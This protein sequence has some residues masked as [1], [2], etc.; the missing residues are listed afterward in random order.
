MLSNNIL[1]KASLLCI[2]VFSVGNTVYASA[3]GLSES[4]SSFRSS[5]SLKPKKSLTFNTRKEVFHYPNEEAVEDTD[6][7]FGA[8]VIPVIA[9]V[10]MEKSK[11]SD[12]RSIVR[13]N[14]QAQY[15]EYLAA[16]T[17]FLSRHPDIVDEELPGILGSVSL[18]LRL[19]KE[20]Y[21]ENETRI[22]EIDQLIDSLN[23]PDVSLDDIYDMK[24]NYMFKYIFYYYKKLIKLFN[25]YNISYNI[26]Y[27]IWQI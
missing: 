27:L 6:D 16:W 4:K 12:H 17:G 22:T 24:Y 3:G 26:L 23:S 13:E 21:P 7:D 11:P 15:D 25:S 14:L 2:V 20:K 18:S 1:S 19:F 5:P 8:K 9:E 10:D